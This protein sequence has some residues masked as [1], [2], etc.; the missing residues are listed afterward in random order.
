MFDTYSSNDAGFMGYQCREGSGLHIPEYHLIVEILDE[1]GHALPPGALGEIV[2]TDL[3]NCS[4]PLIRYGGLGDLGRISLT[5]CPCG[6]ALRVFS[7]IAGRTGTYLTMPDGRRVH[8]FQL[9]TAFES[10][11]GI[12]RYQIVQE[13]RDLVRL[14]VV[15]DREADRSR[16]AAE[17]Q[18][19]GATVFPADM[20]LVI[21][22]AAD[23]ERPPGYRKA[24]VVLCKLTGDSA[25]GSAA[26]Q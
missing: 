7:E 19:R 16:I 13:R 22:L 2:I 12:F 26:A 10:V 3:T 6:S 25:S 20:Q 4:M 18:A 1:D 9:T 14:C 5:P 23:I 17:L 15:P 11:A 24:P 21:E 8:A